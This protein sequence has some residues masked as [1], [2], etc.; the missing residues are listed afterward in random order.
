MNQFLMIFMSKG[1][2]SKK[3]QGK[4]CVNISL[5]EN[6]GKKDFRGNHNKNEKTAN[7]KV[8]AVFFDAIFLCFFNKNMLSFYI[9]L[10]KKFFYIFNILFSKQ[11][12]NQFH[13]F[14]NNFMQTKFENSFHWD[15]PFNQ[16]KR[17]KTI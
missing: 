5:K 8:N 12:W 7:L 2:F 1:D 10:I 3:M 16:L 4:S 13:F 9:I 6:A 17:A 11:R 15:K 14:W